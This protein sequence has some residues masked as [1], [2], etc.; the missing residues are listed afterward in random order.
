MTR[1]F[2]RPVLAFI[3]LAVAAAAAAHE[4]DKAAAGLGKVEF[5]NSCSPAVQEKLVRGVAMLH[6]FY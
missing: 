2:A 4:D 6:S 5:A 1:L 3:L